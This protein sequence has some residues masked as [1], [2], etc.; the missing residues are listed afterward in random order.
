[1]RLPFALLLAL[2]LVAIVIGVKLGIQRDCLIWKPCEESRAFRDCPWRKP[3]ALNSSG[4]RT[5]I[6]TFRHFASPVSATAAGE[7]S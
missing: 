2:V 5:S 3:P 1:M 4:S 6:R 7:Y